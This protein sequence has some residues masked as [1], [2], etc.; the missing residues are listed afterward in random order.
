MVG[1]ILTEISV[2]ICHLVVNACPV[3]D[4]EDEQ[5]SRIRRV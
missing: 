2:C 5:T 1:C 3:E 4:C